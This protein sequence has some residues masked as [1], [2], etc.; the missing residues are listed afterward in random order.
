MLLDGGFRVQGFETQMKELKKGAKPVH[1]FPP[2]PVFHGFEISGAVFTSGDID[3]LA[4]L[5]DNSC[6]NL[7]CPDISKK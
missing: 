1:K 4:Y 6:P 2:N 7:H 5:H 3:T